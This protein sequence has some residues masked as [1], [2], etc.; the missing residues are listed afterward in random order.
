M[1]ITQLGLNTSRARGEA[2]GVGKTVTLRH[3]DTIE[4][5]DGH[6]KYK[7]FFDPAPPMKQAE[8]GKGA[9]VKRETTDIREAF[10]KKRS[11]KLKFF[12]LGLPPPPPISGK[13][14]NIFSCL[15]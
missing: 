5:L 10:K 1:K 8:N 13:V 6:Y 11:K 3:E 7:L 15:F 4:V 14:E 2:I 12:N 9:A